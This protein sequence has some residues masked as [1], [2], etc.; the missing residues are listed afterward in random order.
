[1]TKSRA[2]VVEDEK[3][4][5]E[6]LSADLTALGIDVVATYGDAVAARQG[7]VSLRPDMLFLDIEM[8]VMGGFEL[9]NEFEPHELPPA[10]IFVTAYEQHAVRA[11]GA[12]ALD[13]ILKPTAPA[14]LRA[15]VERAVQRVEEAR[16]AQ[17]ATDDK[18]SYLAQILV[19]DRG[20]TTVIPVSDLEWIE[21]ETYY[22]R[23][24]SARARSCLLRER[25]SVLESR[26]D[27]AVFFRCH[28]SAII[29]LDLV[30]AI[31]TISR[32][33][34]VVVLSTGT[35]VPVSRDR[36]AR[37]QSLLNELRPA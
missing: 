14:R 2:I 30:K 29:R 32:Y 17:A 23:L 4:A 19:R 24:H 20:Q 26:L 12:R 22:V 1:M 9:L 18:A 33:E 25:M 15:A 6:G 36:R 10:I 35:R 37:L 31:K 11:F 34:H 7:I 16:L 13:Y 3:L 5:R 27:P 8:P 21:A 28:R